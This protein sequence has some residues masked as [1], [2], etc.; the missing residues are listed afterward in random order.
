MNT[1][2]ASSEMMQW[3]MENKVGMNE[4]PHANELNTDKIKKI[5]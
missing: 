3:L 5:R 4:M 2:Q 1:L